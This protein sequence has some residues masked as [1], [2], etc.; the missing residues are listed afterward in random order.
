MFR[1][2]FGCAFPLEYRIPQVFDCLQIFHKFLF[3][4]NGVIYRKAPVARLCVLF[5]R[6]CFV[7]NGLINFNLI[8]HKAPEFQIFALHVTGWTG[9][10]KS[11]R[12]RAAFA[13]RVFAC[14]GLMSAAGKT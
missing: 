10:T 5:R 7:R 6:R 3:G 8:V 2:R 9:N 14:Y 4:L 1:S 11:T 13:A 12:T